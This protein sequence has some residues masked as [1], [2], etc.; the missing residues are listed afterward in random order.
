MSALLDPCILSTITGKVWKTRRR[1]EGS[2]YGRHASRHHG[3]SL[4][5]SQHRGYVAG[6]DIKHVDWKLFARTE[7]FFVKQFRAETNVRAYIVLDASASMDFPRGGGDT[8]GA[9]APATR[10]KFDYARKI[11]AAAAYVF[12]AQG[13]AVGIYIA[14]SVSP[15]FIPDGGGW[16]RFDEIIRALDTARPQGH[17]GLAEA[18]GEMAAKMKK[19][20]LFLLISDLLEDSGDILASLQ[21]LSSMRH[22]CR[23][24]QILDRGETL[25]EIVSPTRATDSETLSEIELDPAIIAE[26]R[27]KMAEEIALYKISLG[28]H[29]VGYDLFFTDEPPE[30]NLA[31]LLV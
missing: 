27:D 16:G 4:D 5:F 25:L 30:K 8:V 26:Y 18:A 29:S 17:C 13:D 10:T 3:Q 6:D 19:R 22:E 11:A 2:L 20:S 9:V 1:A 28:K 31:R 15:L 24:V 14:N 21:R 23:V 7:R 12:A